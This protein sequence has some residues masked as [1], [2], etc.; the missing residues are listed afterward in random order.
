MGPYPAGISVTPDGKYIYVANFESSSITVI[1]A[2]T[3]KVLRSIAVA[4]DPYAVA[5][6]PPSPGLPFSDFKIAGLGVVHG[7]TPNQGSFD[8]YSYF[9]LGG[10]S[11]GIHPDV[12]PVTLD[13]GGF[14]ATIP[15]GSYAKAADG[16]FVFVKRIK[17]V[18]YNSFI[19]PQGGSRYL[20]HLSE[21]GLDLP[22]ITNPVQVRQMIGDD[23]GAVTVKAIVK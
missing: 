11:N 1:D 23:G 22:A 12:E 21:T 17:G 10:A 8:Y 18:L 6:I 7:A 16:S 5:M 14:T 13:I 3:Y 4:T 9:T 2:E 19:R 20:I 15:A